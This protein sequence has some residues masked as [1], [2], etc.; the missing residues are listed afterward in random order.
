MRKVGFWYSKLEPT[1]PMPVNYS[2]DWEGGADF[3]AVL[4]MLQIRM[5]NSHG[6]GLAKREANPLGEVCQ[7]KGFSICRLC[8]SG[9]GSRE[10]TLRGFTWPEG[11]LHYLQE[12][13]FVPP[14]P[15]FQQFIKD[16]AK[17]HITVSG[18]QL[19]L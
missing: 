13:H 14:D 18:K 5:S 15:E 2:G 7:Y 8:G 1:L 12:P 9:N 17:E 3:R 11:Y 10:F 6:F 19:G 16:W 4:I